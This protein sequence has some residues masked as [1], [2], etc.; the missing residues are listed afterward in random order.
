MENPSWW[1]L[2]TAWFKKLQDGWGMSVGWVG[3]VVLSCT[4]QVLPT[5][6][7]QLISQLNSKSNIFVDGNV[8]SCVAKGGTNL[9]YLSDFSILASSSLSVV[10][11][12][13]FYLTIGLMQLKTFS[14]SAHGYRSV[15]RVRR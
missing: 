3:L 2:K 13:A 1:Y 10:G 8:C 4:K 15:S 9:K 5:C 6:F 14:S 7:L 11:C 12:T